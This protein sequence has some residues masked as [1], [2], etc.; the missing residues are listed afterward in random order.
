MNKIANGLK[1]YNKLLIENYPMTMTS[2][3][4]SCGYYGYN[5]KKNIAI[6]WNGVYMVL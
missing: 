3:I 6:C 5:L 1:N 4:I 2:G